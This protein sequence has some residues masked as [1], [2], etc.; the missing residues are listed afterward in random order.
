MEK[1]LDENVT[2]LIKDNL[3]TSLD[4]LSSN[5]EV[6]PWDILVVDLIK[7]KVVYADWI[8]SEYQNG[9]ISNS[10]VSRNKERVYDVDFED[11]SK[12][13][14]MK[15]EYI[16]LLMKT[17]SNENDR[18]KDIKLKEGIRV[19]FKTSQ[20]KSSSNY[21]IKYYPGRIVE[22]NKN[23]LFS[24]EYENGVSKNVTQDDII[25]GLASGQNVEAKKAEYVKLECTSVSWNSTGNSL[26]TSYGKVSLNG[27]NNFPGAITMWNIFS[28]S[29]NPIILDHN[30]PIS[31]TKYHPEIPSL[32][33]SS[34]FNGEVM[35]WNTT[36]PEIPVA[37]SLISFYSHNGPVKQVL[38]CKYL[39]NWII[40]SCGV[41]G[42]ILFWT[43]SNGLQFPFK[44]FYVSAEHNKKL[45]FQS[46]SSISISDIKRNVKA[47]GNSYSNN[48]SDIVWIIIGLESGKLCRIQLNK[49]FNQSPTIS[50][51]TIRKNV[52]LEDVFVP[53]LK[54]EHTVYDGHIGPVN[55]I[56]QS[57]FHRNLFLTAG[58]D[59]FLRLYHT[60]GRSPLLKWEP[61]SNVVSVQ[62]PLTA[63]A[64]SPFR[65]C[66]WACSSSNGN[67]FI[68]DY[69]VSKCVPVQTLDIESSINSFNLK[70][71]DPILK[72]K[73]ENIA[74]YDK[75]KKENSGITDIA[76]NPKQRDFIASATITGEIHIWKMSSHFPKLEEQSIIDELG[77]TIIN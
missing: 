21:S 46:V 52:P 14:S 71:S 35:I 33:I 5:S 56:D 62:T 29:Q 3:N 11:G 7:H 69:F 13:V 23:G 64:F 58:D 16:R 36:K 24:I 57:P 61:V 18:K 1:L 25:I 26:A 68:F 75:S 28:Q 22:C 20:N 2:S 39:G 42:K 19:H 15:E 74:K 31:L 73:K 60:L 9:R 41:D 30:C 65:P 17:G 76:F 32:L 67:V 53:L 10:S 55:S 77:N 27:W 48:V 34:T 49:I 63:C 12:Q 50:Q 66:V 43:E 70:N 40:I 8:N 4:N 44:G 37:T 72:T 54:Y 45:T 6:L 38:W 51:D 47:T 59:G